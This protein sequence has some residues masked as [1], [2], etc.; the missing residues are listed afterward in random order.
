MTSPQSEQPKATPSTSEKQSTSILGKIEFLLFLFALALG[1]AIWLWPQL[2]YWDILP[3]FASWWYQAGTWFIPSSSD[4]LTLLIPTL[5]WLIILGVM[6][7]VFAKP[8]IWTRAFASIS[9]VILGARYELWR[10]FETINLDDPLNGTLSVLLFVME[11]VTF[12]NTAAFLLHTI[13]T[14]DR[15]PEADRLSQAVIAKTYQPTVDVLIPTYN[16]PADILRRTVIGCQ[17]MDYERKQIYL[18]DDLRRPQIRALAAELGCHYFDRPD[19]SHAKAGNVNHALGQIHGELV[20]IFDADFIPTTDFLTRTVGFFQDEKVAMVQTPQ[21][22]Y[23]EDPVSVNLGL[24][25]VLTNE[26]TLFFRYIQ[27]SRD[28]TNSVICCGT[29][30]IVRRS[31]LDEIGGIPTES[32]TEDF[33]TSLHL[34]GR[35]YRIKYLNEAVSAGMSPE[36][37]G[38]YISQRL[39]WGQGTIQTLFC[40]TNIFSLPGLNPIQRLSHSLGLLYW[41][42]ALPRLCFL[43][44]PLAYLLFE[45]APLRATVE[46][47]L[48]FYVPYYFSNLLVFSWLTGGRRSSFWSD[49]YETLLCF[50]MTL[51][52]FRTLW[53]PFGKGFKV[54]PKGVTGTQLHVNWQLVWPPLLIMFLCIFGITLRLTRLS[55]STVNPD[56]LMVNVFW[57]FYNLG[58]LYICIFVAVDVP[59]RAHA[60]FK[61]RHPCELRSPL[62][63]WQGHSIDLSEGGAA[64]CLRDN[65]DRVT[66]PE[67]AEL[68]LEAIEE[69]ITVE[70][71][72]QKRTKDQQWVVGVLFQNPS[73]SVQRQLVKLLYCT[74]GQ[75][76][77]QSISEHV[78]AWA[79]IKS[80]FR[81][82]AVAETR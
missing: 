26:Q 67:Q 21:N 73:L 79:F 22:F 51:T 74:P 14:I 34:Q 69:P 27:P 52:I 36:T 15:S 61:L 63:V 82:Y 39:R 7:E 9:L 43:L 50:P 32:I 80:I 64:L 1:T 78:T 31:A 12:L 66:F 44:M 60:R 24:Q 40:K 13:V 47:I 30:F 65:P 68:W 42:L 48:A 59:Q 53:K 54:T 62:G 11:L 18:L 29:C 16:E 75:W 58:L 76:Q 17:A 3:E 10:F 77:E 19:N 38:D 6:R 2:R 41:F 56:S 20:V 57:T 45:L 33:F 81:M 23:N 8:S 46:G 37:I 71:R 25:S 4:R 35:G 28:V 70:L 72:W 5:G 49:V 55:W